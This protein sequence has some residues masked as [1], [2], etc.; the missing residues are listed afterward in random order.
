MLFR[1][2][3]LIDFWHLLEH[4]GKAAKACGNDSTTAVPRF[5]DALLASDDAIDAIEVEVHGWALP[6]PDD[7]LPDDLHA[8]MTYIENNRARLR[9]ATTYAAGLPIG[10][11]TVEATGK[12]IVETRMRRSGARW[13]ESGAQPILALRALATSSG[14]RWGEAIGH[15]INSYKATVRPLPPRTRAQA[16][17]L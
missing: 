4:L 11:G 12:T 5:R 1:S 16:R 9:Y 10:S 8:A 17:S 2:A 15:V 6:Y 14:A 3:R 13:V 7:E